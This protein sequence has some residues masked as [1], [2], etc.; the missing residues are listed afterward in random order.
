M[1]PPR[2]HPE[3]DP[4]PRFPLIAGEGCEVCTNQST[5]DAA[6]GDMADAFQ[7]TMLRIQDGLAKSRE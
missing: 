5:E 2:N 4:A 7:M 3:A 1:Q 6:P